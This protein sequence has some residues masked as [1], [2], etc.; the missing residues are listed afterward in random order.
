[1]I[2][3]WAVAQERLLMLFMYAK[4]ERDDVSPAQLKVLREIV[5]DEYP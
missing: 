5:E 4:G 3:Y 2:Y 1:M